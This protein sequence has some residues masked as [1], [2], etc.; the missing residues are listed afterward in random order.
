MIKSRFNLVDI[1]VKIY[2]LLRFSIMFYQYILSFKLYLMFSS[3]Q[4][5]KDKNSKV[6]DNSIFIDISSKENM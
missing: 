4:K 1:V 6:E 5:S 3:P 2:I